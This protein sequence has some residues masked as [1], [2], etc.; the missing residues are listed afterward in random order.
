[1]PQG[2]HTFKWEFKKTAS[3]NQFDNCFY[4][5][6]LSICADY[7]SVALNNTVDGLTAPSGTYYLVASSTSDEFTVNIEKE[8]IPLPV[9]ASSPTPNNGL[10][11]YGNSNNSIGLSW[12]LGDY[13]KEYQVLFGETNPPTAELVGWTNELND[14]CTVSVNENKTYYWRVN[15]RNGS[16]VTEGPVW[17]FSYTESINA[18]A[19]NIIYV[20]S[21]GAGSKVG[22]SW[23][24]A[25][26][27]IQAAIDYAASI[28]SN[29]PVIWVAKGTYTSPLEQTI[30]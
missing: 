20:T 29:Q 11:I 2:L 3:Y 18:S 12:Q 7:Q 21:T 15:E 19:D 30:S 23:A 8:V 10:N 26:S 17:A 1:M 27:S 13:T 4:I 6:N 16:G 5:D 24:D 25:A 14:N 28:T 9:A 22:S